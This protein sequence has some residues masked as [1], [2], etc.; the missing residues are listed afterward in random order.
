MKGKEKSNAS[1]EFSLICS[2]SK[3]IFYI[4]KGG[5]SSLRDPISGGRQLYTYLPRTS[6]GLDGWWVSH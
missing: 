2:N 6:K 1:S 4:K 3:K 5:L